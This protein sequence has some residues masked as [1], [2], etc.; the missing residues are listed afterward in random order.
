MPTHRL[1]AVASLSTL[2]ACAAVHADDEK[3]KEPSLAHK[4]LEAHLEKAGIA[5]AQ[6]VPLKSAVLGKALPGQAFF[7]VRFRQYPVAVAPPEGM[8]S[9]N[10]FAVA[11]TGKPRLMRDAAELE[12]FLRGNLAGVGKAQVESA[13]ASYLTLAQEL[14]QDGFY[15]FEVLTKGFAVEDKGNDTIE[16]AGRAMV[17]KGG[18]GELNVTM[19]FKDRKLAKVVASSKLRPGPRPRCQATKLLDP[20]PIVREM[21]EQ[22]L[23]YMGVAARQYI[24]EQ[25]AKAAPQLRDAI[26]R[27][28]RRIE[29]EGW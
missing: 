11:R 13:L 1:L 25:R 14:H 9:A 23:L 19:I 12:K 17:T 5:N 16:A 27:L 2:V 8:N 21:A 20:D 28:W 7:A 26:D 6:I 22:A 29:K 3:V 10:V 24:M 18:N 15:T 4:A